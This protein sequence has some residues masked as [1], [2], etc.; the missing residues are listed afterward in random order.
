MNV[1]IMGCGRVGAQLAMA[2]DAEGHK[3]TIMDIEPYSFRRLPATFKG[4]ALIGNGLDGEALRK[5]GI[6]RAD[7]FVAV[8]QGDNR[9]VMAAQIAKHIFNVPK[10]VCR[11]YDPIR[12]EMYRTLGLETISPTMVGAELLKRAIA[13][14]E[15]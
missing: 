1:L 11:I 9:N 14:Q 4:T 12:E 13:G 8:T 5:A 6:E 15:G 7:V 10:A 2:M 3:V